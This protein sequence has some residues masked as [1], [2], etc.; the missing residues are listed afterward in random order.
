[1]EIIKYEKYKLLYAQN[2]RDSALSRTALSLLCSS[3][4]VGF[5][6]FIF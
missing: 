3:F 2:F 4:F 6:Y 1:M 5:K